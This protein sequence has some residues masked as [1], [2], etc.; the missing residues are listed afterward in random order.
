M[1]LCLVVILCSFG[2]MTVM[3]LGIFGSPVLGF[4]III[5]MITLIL[6]FWGVIG[7]FVFRRRLVITHII[8]AELLTR[9]KY[10]TRQW[11]S[12]LAVNRAYEK[13]DSWNGKGY[14]LTLSLTTPLFALGFLGD[15]ISGAFAVALMATVSMLMPILNNLIY[16]KKQKNPEVY[17]SRY[18]AYVGG[19]LLK[20][21][22]SL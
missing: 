8:G 19:C 22:N 20:F 10:E 11:G 12:W 21:F 7:F 6:L 16:R 1:H 2:L 3:R 15:A 9:W 14:I 4:L 18:G 17:L 5:V 13:L